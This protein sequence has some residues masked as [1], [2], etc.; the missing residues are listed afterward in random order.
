MQAQ[1]TQIHFKTTM[2]ST[3]HDS[4]YVVFTGHSTVTVLQ[5]LIFCLSKAFD[6]FITKAELH[7]KQKQREMT[8]NTF[9]LQ[10]HLIATAINDNVHVYYS[11]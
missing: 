4:V 1:I 5:T 11:S 3:H 6:N 8:N 7:V 10:T 9:E 2:F